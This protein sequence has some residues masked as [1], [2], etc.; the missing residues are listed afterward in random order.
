[1]GLLDELGKV[2]GGTAA[3]KVADLATKADVQ[4]RGSEST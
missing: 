2:V 4:F 3:G 1:M